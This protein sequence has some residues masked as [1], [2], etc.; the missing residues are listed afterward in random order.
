MRNIYIFITVL[1]LLSC[2]KGFSQENDNDYFV[3]SSDLSVYKFRSIGPAMISGRISDLAVNPDDISE[4]YVAVASGGVFKTENSGTTFK[5]IFDSQRPYS[6]GCISIAPSNK[7]VVWIGTGENNS[8][9]SVSYGDGVYKSSDGGK[10]WKNTGLKNSKHIGMIT[11]HPENENI[12]YVAAQGPL[13]G[14]GG[15]RGLYKTTDGGENWKKILEISENTGINEV[16]M[17][18]RNP[19]VL[20][21]SSYQ[22]RRHVYTLING[23]PESAIYK[24]VD[25]GENWKKLSKGLP[26]NDKGKI[27]L[28]IAKS[29]PDYVYAIIEAAENKG[30][31]F[32]STDRGESW[33]KMSSYVA[34]SPQYYNEIFVDPIDENKIYSMDTYSQ[35]SL[36]GG[37]TWKRFSLKSRH[38]DDHALWVNPDNT[39]HLLIGGDG[40]L[41][42][43][44]DGG[45]N[46]YYKQ[47]LPLSQFYRVEVDN[48]KPF[49]YVYGGTQDNNS[50]GGPSQT[51]DNNGIINTDWFITH[52]GDGFEP[53]ID[54]ENPNIVYTQS[55]YGWVAR[56]NRKT[57]EEI[58]IK[59]IEKDN[60]EAYRWNWDSPLLISPHNNKRLYFAANKVFKSEN[61]GNKWEVISP[62]LTRQINRNELKVMGKIQSPEA[63]SKNAST[64][65]YGNIV[66]LDES[67]MKEGLL[68]AGTDD[69]QI[70][71][72]EDGGEN[73]KTYNE[74]PDIPKLA[75][76]S[77]IIAS[78]FDENVVYASFEN[79]KDNDFKPYILKSENKGKS[80]KSI[81]NN[82]PKDEMVWAI[83]QDHKKADMLFVGT[84]FGVF[85][86]LN[87]GENWVELKS[88]LP[89]IAIR[90]IDIQ[91]RENDLALASYG[92]GFYILDDYSSLRNIENIITKDTNHIFKVK[93]A[94]MF[95]YRRRFGGGKKGHFGDH[96]FV[97]DNPK[98]GAKIKYYLNE[99]F[100]SLKQKRKKEEKEAFK[101]DE[102]I[103]YPD[104]DEFY[105]EDFEIKDYLMFIITDSD[106]N[107]IRK[108]KAS[109][110]KGTHEII[111]DLKYPSTYRITGKGKKGN[112][113]N[114][115]GGAFV[116]PGVY[117]V[118]MAIVSKN[119]IKKIGNKQSFNVSRL[120]NYENTDINLA[121]GF[122]KDVLRLNKSLSSVNHEINVI[123]KKLEKIKLSLEGTQGADLKYLYQV[124]NIISQMDSIDIIMNGNPAKKKRNASYAPGLNSRFGYTIWG[125]SSSMEEATATHQRDLKIVEDRLNEIIDFI[126]DIN[127][128][129]IPELEKELDRIGAPHT[130]GRIIRP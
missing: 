17:D 123:N 21:A 20:Y 97:A 44:F 79:H 27:G 84:E 75:Y 60:G 92:R 18:P 88:G 26:S 64:S 13:W 38:V 82:L 128:N 10:S 11:I 14:A 69:G 89:S 125:I 107:E 99:N 55:Q 126:E 41:Y 54:P 24:S 100:E 94:N 121:T 7:N 35:Y 49:Y 65:I 90:D 108:L 104:F 124:R 105:K 66:S 40:G 22:R 19:D 109:V 102:D 50:V 37:K 28:A 6:I 42:E 12:V 120:H 31:T 77:D 4:Y 15:D 113:N 111:W 87:D 33:T 3:K 53:Q 2:F 74:F 30:G 29:N 34:R 98:Q 63:V 103:D 58:L 45:K 47:N 68:Y 8:Q 115:S 57:G 51:F 112:F 62:D 119:G 48:S 36:D 101:N 81:S 39:E 129:K 122:R 23:G 83:A 56:Y 72:S 91:E 93:D 80:W 52:G 96:F 32:R 114:N 71:V 61:R 46:F 78:K 16:I 130:P 67:P 76:V 1:F 9:R 43:S 106:G 127:D 118:E 116:L 25:G 86:T 95:K 5:S 110:S 70:S 85:F 73:W 117:Y 59:P